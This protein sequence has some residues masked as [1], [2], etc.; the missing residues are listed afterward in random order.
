MEEETA[1]AAAAALEQRVAEA[2]EARAAAK[3]QK[4][5]SRCMA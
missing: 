3:A 1:L 2:K 4:K 5:V